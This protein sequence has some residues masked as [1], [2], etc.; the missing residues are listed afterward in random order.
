VHGDHAD[1][2]CM[3]DDGAD[4]DDVDVNDQLYQ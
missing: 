4:H 2:E 1:D 3:H